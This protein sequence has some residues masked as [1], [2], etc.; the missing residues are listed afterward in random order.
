MSAGGLGKGVRGIGGGGS[1]RHELATFPSSCTQ[2]T[3]WDLLSNYFP[4]SGK[5][6]FPRCI[7]L[8]VGQAI[9][10]SASYVS[11][12]DTDDECV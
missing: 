12:L 1:L 4:S 11:I 10:L 5:K 3:Q 8:L 6:T 7:F 2:R 9:N